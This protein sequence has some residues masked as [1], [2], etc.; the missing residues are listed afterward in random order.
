MT[1]PLHPR[2]EAHGKVIVL[3]EHAV[4]YGYPAVA[5][6]LP[7]GIVLEAQPRPDPRL[8]V[9][10]TI[11]AWDLDLEL[12]PASDHPVARACLE[13]LA[14]C[15]GPVT[16]WAIR[17]ASALPSRAGLGSSAALTVA[18]AR[19]VYGPD[20]SIEDVVAA[21]LAGERVFHGEPSGL[22]SRVAAQG[23]VLRYVRGE[24][25]RAINPGAPLPLCIIPSG[26]PRSTADQV[27]RCRSRLEHLPSVVRPVL[28]AVGQ[29]VEAG[30]HAIEHG[31]L[32]SLGVLFDVAHGLLGALDVSSPALDRMAADARAAGARG[33]KLTGAG[34][35]GCLL[36]LVGDAPESLTAAFPTLRPLFVEVAAS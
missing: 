26:I 24:P 23:G 14:H 11:P 30:I 18:L 31:D 17:G 2:A 16:G 22:D 9:T 35:G 33:A 4:V 27:A 28:I 36:A 29:A 12:H 15:D 1:I 34:R 19:L 21:S 3:G 20:A 25:P 10:L 32:D 6:G 7:Q 8:P 5:A 13:V